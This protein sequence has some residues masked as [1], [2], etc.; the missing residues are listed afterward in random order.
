MVGHLTLFMQDR[1]Q[2][3]VLDDAYAFNSLC[4]RDLE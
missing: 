3:T 4:G 1:H 2:V